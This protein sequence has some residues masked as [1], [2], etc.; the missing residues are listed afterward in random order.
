MSELERPG[1][2]LLFSSCLGDIFKF[3][4]D[5]FHILE[6]FNILDIHGLSTL[7]CL[8]NPMWFMLIGMKLFLLEV[9]AD[10]ASNS[11]LPPMDFE[12]LSCCN[13]SEDFLDEYPSDEVSSNESYSSLIVFMRSDCT[14]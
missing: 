14:S 3:A 4:E 1:K 11:I 12:R 5:A 8:T 2:L 13:S 6:V 7:F 10:F 9:H